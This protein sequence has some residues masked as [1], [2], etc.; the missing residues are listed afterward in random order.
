[1]IAWAPDRKHS[2]YEI[3]AVALNFPESQAKFILLFLCR[4]VMCDSYI[5]WNNEVTTK[6][7]KRRHS[8][9]LLCHNTVTGPTVLTSPWFFS[10]PLQFFILENGGKLLSGLCHW[11]PQ[12]CGSSTHWDIVSMGFPKRSPTRWKAGFIGCLKFAYSE[13]S[14]EIAHSNHEQN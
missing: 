1:M 7:I 4:T 6:A 5:S 8:N 3:W 2:E 13:W 9:I 12:R 14:V 10:Y 11:K